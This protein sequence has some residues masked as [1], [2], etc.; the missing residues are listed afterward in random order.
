MPRDSAARGRW[1][2]LPRALF[3]FDL[4]SRWH[5]A[6][7]PDRGQCARLCDSALVACSYP[8]GTSI[9]IPAARMGYQ[10]TARHRLLIEDV[11]VGLKADIE[12]LVRE[13]LPRGR[14]DGAEYR[15][16]SISGE[17]GKSLAIHLGQD[18][19]GIWRDFAAGIGGNV[20]DLVA[21]VV[22]DG[23]KRR[24]IAWASNWLA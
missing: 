4:P 1:C 11:A 18:K 23:D 24:A 22:C 19:P 21:A 8:Q 6:M 2:H 5:F 14:R 16:G 3:D 20:L 12:R 10:V 13:I 7:P 17:S 15:V 9:Q